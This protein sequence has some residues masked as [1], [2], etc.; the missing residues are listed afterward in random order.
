MQRFMTLFRNT[1]SI[2]V[3]SSFNGSG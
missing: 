1:D 3:V 2:R